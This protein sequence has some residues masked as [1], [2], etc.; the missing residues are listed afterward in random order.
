MKLQQGGEVCVGA[1]ITS[2]SVLLP[3]SP[4]PLIAAPSVSSID[5]F[6]HPLLSPLNSVSFQLF[7]PLVSFQ[8]K[9]EVNN[10]S[11]PFTGK[12]SSKP[13]IE[14]SAKKSTYLMA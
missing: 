5:P 9:L 1:F 3:R 7:L 8:T 13:S 6:K 10:A 11:P 2:P 4:I 12:P 14:A